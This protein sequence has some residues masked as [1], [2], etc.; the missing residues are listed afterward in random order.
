MTCLQVGEIEKVHEEGALPQA[1]IDVGHHS[2][3]LS[4]VY[5]EQVGAGMLESLE[6]RVGDKKCRGG[7]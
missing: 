4:V 3:H 7:S 1:L 2:E 6:G 5:Q